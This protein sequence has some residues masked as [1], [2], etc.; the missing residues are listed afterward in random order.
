[1]I[2]HEL[3]TNAGKYGALSTPHGRVLVDWGVAD[4]TA[5]KLKLSWRELDGPK[6][7]PPD[8]RGFGSRL[9]ERNIRHDLA[10]EIDL[11]YGKDGL[12]AE[13][14]VPLDRTPAL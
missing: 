4:Q 5:P 1:M 14:M 10:G 11:V 13:L 12:I 7:T 8:T 2:F 6:V 9:I 3:A